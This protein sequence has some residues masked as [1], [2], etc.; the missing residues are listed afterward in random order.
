MHDYFLKAS[1]PAVLWAALEKA[2]LARWVAPE[3]DERGVETR[4]GAWQTV[5]CLVDEIGAIVRPNALPDAPPVVLAG[6]H[7]NLRLGARLTAEQDAA[8]APILIPA[9]RQHAREWAGGMRS[10]LRFGEVEPEPELP[11]A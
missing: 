7:A 10:G 4:Q 6:H 2:G 11:G 8:L 3:I 9:P 1:E 5:A